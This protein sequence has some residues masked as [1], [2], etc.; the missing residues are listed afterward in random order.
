MKDITEKMKSQV[1]EIKNELSR[2][3]NSA[4]YN[5]PQDLLETI[6]TELYES[7]EWKQ[8]TFYNRLSGFNPI[9][10]IEKPV[11]EQVF[12]KYGFK[13]FNS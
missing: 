2:Q 3:F 6:K 8:R 13:V 1:K 12:N 10:K 5:L 11:I 9:K 7:L 4:Y